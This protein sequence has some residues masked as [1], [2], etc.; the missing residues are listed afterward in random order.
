MLET[1]TF[2][3]SLDK[4]HKSIKKL[5]LDEQNQL[6]PHDKY[7]LITFGSQCNTKLNE[8]LH[9]VK[10]FK[11]NKETKTNAYLLIDDLVENTLSYKHKT[12]FIINK[13][14]KK[15]NNKKDKLF[16]FLF[17]TSDNVINSVNGLNLRSKTTP[18]NKK[19]DK[20]TDTKKI[21]LSGNNEWLRDLLLKKALINN[22]NI[23]YVRDNTL[24]FPNELLSQYNFNN[25]KII[26]AFNT[27]NLIFKDYNQKSIITKFNTMIKTRSDKSN[28]RFIIFNNNMNI[29]YDN[30]TT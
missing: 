5:V 15:I 19:V 28:I 17:N 2:K 4:K 3:N 8:P 20:I 30:Y 21:E 9:F 18:D 13:L 1:N 7:I 24:Q 16:N 23:I 14:F 10:Y 25:Y 26:V 27:D 29:L 12:Q 6:S 11:N 22:K